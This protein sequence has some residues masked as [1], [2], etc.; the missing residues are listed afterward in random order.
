MNKTITLDLTNT[1]ELLF[2]N[3]DDVVKEKETQLFISFLQA[4]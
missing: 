2:H 1:F 4:W 3:H